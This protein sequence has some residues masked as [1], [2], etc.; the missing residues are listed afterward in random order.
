M[1]SEQNDLGVQVWPV[2]GSRIPESIRGPHTIL[3]SATL[4]VVWVENDSPHEDIPDPEGSRECSLEMDQVRFTFDDIRKASFERIEGYICEAIKKE[5]ECIKGS[6][7]PEEII[8]TWPQWQ[9]NWVKF[10]L[11]QSY[12][13]EPNRGNGAW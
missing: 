7:T 6:L 10:Y 9:Q 13:E 1:H 12:P 8:A 5:S 4:G 3:C 11:N 2:P